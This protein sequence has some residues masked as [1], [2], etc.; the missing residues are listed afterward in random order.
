MKHVTVTAFAGGDCP[1][2]VQIDIFDVE[3]EDLVGPRPGLVEQPP[4]AS[5][6]QVHVAAGEEPV[7]LVTG[8]GPGVVFD[9]VPTLQPLGHLRHHPPMAACVG[10]E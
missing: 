1:L 5:V 2:G 7:Q 3:V 4:K 9:H 8:H 6:T 10:G